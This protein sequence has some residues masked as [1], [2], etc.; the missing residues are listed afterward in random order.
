MLRSLYSGV[1]G[2]KVHQTKMDVIGN[3]ISN[4]NTI[5][6]KSSSV[7]FSDVFYQT[8]Q[9]AT[10]A[11][12]ETG[13]GGTNA[14]QIGLGASIGSIT[15][16][17]STTGAA[18]RT[19]E[20]FDIM[21]NGDAFFVVNSGGTN[22]F[23]KAGAFTVDAAGNLC[24]SSGALVMGWQPDQANPDEIVVDT[25]TPLKVMS[26]DNMFSAP[27]ASTDAYI[28]G[29][30]DKLDTQLA[31][32]GKTTQ[33]AFYDNM[34]NKYSAKMNIK[35]S[36]TSTEDYDV[37]VTDIVDKDGKSLFVT[38]TTDAAGNV[39]YSSTG[40]TFEF[41]GVTYTPTV[42][43]TTG[44]VTL[45]GTDTAT[46]DPATVPLK[47]NGSNGK[48]ISINGGNAAGLSIT[49]PDGQPNPFET[50]NVDFSS[51][52]MFSTNGNSSISA[53]MGSLTGTGAGKQVGNMTGIGVD[54]AGKIYGKYDNGD[55]I[56]LG[57]IAVANF[58]NPAGL[59]SIGGNLFAET[60]NSG[61]FDGI[62]LDPTSGGGSLSTGMLE[63]SN[64]DLS[65]QFTEMIT[66]QRGFQACSRII[67]TSDTLLEELI[68]LKR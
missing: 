43:A 15:T 22:Y 51:L 29:N 47:F 7:R 11:N 63:M 66:T 62:G 59:E 52:T 38:S 45:T 48:F 4:V 64:V 35:Q 20:P 13:T 30:I 39:T 28:S 36:T 57:Q 2:V 33:I 16:S 14:M 58:Q 8:T 31:S 19:D 18:Q 34:G 55:S 21:I 6:F 46:G 23:T 5:G 44:K 42:D 9:K 25:V 40:A 50:V 53:T 17:V 27:Q 65:A 10:G 24:T 60:Q 56:L 37:S 67:T 54:S 3:N 49:M 41:G 26:A 1:S 32:V 61:T 12:Q 68:N